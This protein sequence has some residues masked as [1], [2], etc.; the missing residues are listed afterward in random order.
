MIVGFSLSFDPPSWLGAMT[1]LANAVGD[2]VAFCAKFGINIRPEDWP[3]QHLPAIIEGDRGE[4][5]GNKTLGI[6]KR[7]HIDVQNAAAYRADWKGIVEQRFRLLQQPWRAYVEGYVDTDYGDRGARD[8]RLDAVL[9]IDDL[10]RIIIRQ[11]LYYNNYHELKKYP[12]LPEMTE[13]GVPSV[14][15]ELWNWGIAMKGGMPRQPREEPFL[16]ALLPTAEVSVTPQGIYYHGAHYTCPRAVREK[17]FTK[18][19]DHRFKVT[20]SYDKRDGD[21]IYVHD[22]K[23]PDGFEVGELTPSS[24]RR[25]CSG[26]E[27][28]GLIRADAA[29]SADRRDVQ[30]LRR[31]E[32]DMENEADVA[33]AKAKFEDLSDPGTLREQVSGM[34]GARAEE[35]EA[36]RLED[37]AEYRERM[38]VTASSPEGQGA[39]VLQFE[40][41]ADRPD[42]A[43]AAPSM[44]QMMELKRGRPK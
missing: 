23:A 43:F 20:I 14:P 6:L 9:D 31:I 12:R 17:W 8:Y 4:M 5:E 44:R 36:D 10:T 24:R 42:D 34:R 18:A 35:V 28:E 1:A 27:I 41:V 22:D 19:R 3:C 16:F 29:Q 30:T 32:M 25:G 37:A 7:F 39:V 40:P 33:A 15:R 21:R 38:G 2:K 11:V 26:W 13:D